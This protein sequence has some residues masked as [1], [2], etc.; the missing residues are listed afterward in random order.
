MEVSDRAAAAAV[1]PLCAT[2]GAISRALPKPKRVTE[3]SEKAEIE[4]S[5]EKRRRVTEKSS[6]KTVPAAKKK[7]KEAVPAAKKKEKAAVEE[8][9]EEKPVLEKFLSPTLS[10][11]MS[12]AHHRAYNAA[13]KAG[14]SL[15]NIKAV[16]SK[17]RLE[18]KEAWHAREATEE[19]VW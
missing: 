11:T 8:K 3:K 13:K 14:M 12:R 2:V 9:P 7:E 5:S 15:Q 1:K 16:A 19:D 6:E 18:A 17:A 4:K 10:C